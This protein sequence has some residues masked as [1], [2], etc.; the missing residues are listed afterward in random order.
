MRRASLALTSLLLCWAPLAADEVRFYEKEGVTY[1][2]SRRVVR[3]PIA[4]TRLEDRTRTVYREQWTAETQET[5]QNAYVPVTEYRWEAYWE[6]RWN[7]FRQPVLAQRLVP[8]TR[9]ETR[10]EV[11]RVPRLRR[12]LVPETRTEKVPVAVE[13]LV[14]EEVITRSAVAVSRPADPFAPA[15]I[16]SLAR[17]EPI[18]GLARLENDPPRQGTSGDW[19]AARDVTRR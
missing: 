11:V 19:R 13:R 7:P 9:W 5:L 10:Q 3:R 15:G 8:R 1:R 18:G 16:R 14:E 6:G 2:E 17:R 4:E 12:E